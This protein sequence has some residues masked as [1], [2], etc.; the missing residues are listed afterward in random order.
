MDELAQRR[1]QDHINALLWYVFEHSA[2]VAETTAQGYE[3]YVD[4]VNAFFDTESFSLSHQ[5][6][7]SFRIACACGWSMS[8]LSPELLT[9]NPFQ[10]VLHQCVRRIVLH[11][12]IRHDGLKAA[13]PLR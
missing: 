6:E 5:A 4:S 9:A 8:L 10:A 12:E 7:N 2:R 11:F 3:R 1:A 13:Q